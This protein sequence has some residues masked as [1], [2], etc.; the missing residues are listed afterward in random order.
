MKT[1]L[2][3]TLALEL[4]TQGIKLMQRHNAA[5]AAG[6]AEVPDAEIRSELDTAIAKLDGL[7][8]SA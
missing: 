7:N 6:K 1:E 2:I 8:Q 3:A 5:V 4:L